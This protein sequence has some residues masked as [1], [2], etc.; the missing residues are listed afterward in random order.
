MLL[1]GTSGFSYDA[2]RGSF[3]PEDLPAERMLAFYGSQLASVEVNNTFYRM[4]K[5][6]VLEQW[7][8]S[9]PEAFR[10]AIKASR[11][12]THL[13]RLKNV[14][15]SVGYLLNVTASLGQ[16]L[17]VLLFQLPPFLRRDDTLLADFLAL[18]PEGTPAALEV[19][20]ASWYDDAVFALLRARNVVLVGGDP[21]EG[22]RPMPL[23]PTADFGYLRLR[24]PDYSE[25]ELAAWS[26]RIA[27]QPWK[28]TF[29]FFKHED[30]GPA[31]ARRLAQI[32]GA[33]AGPGLA[34]VAEPA[35]PSVAAAEPPKP[36]RRARAKR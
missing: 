8:S 11:R 12:I 15:D 2:W 9:T 18:L 24:A 6:S 25:S 4:P 21:D 10:F 27:A 7:A 5:P 32:A 22:D 3:Y 13:G 23:V 16:K 14:D 36:K 1:T 30:K 28:T 17:G 29:A 35:G 33:P 20:H 26:E 19:R 34:K 31:L